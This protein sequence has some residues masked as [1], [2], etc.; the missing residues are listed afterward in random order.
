MYSPGLHREQAKCEQRFN[1][2][3]RFGG[4]N[5]TKNFAPRL[6]NELF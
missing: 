3:G 4:R 6:S 1:F 2:S 5:P